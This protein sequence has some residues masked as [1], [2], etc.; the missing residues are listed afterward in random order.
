M[1]FAAEFINTLQV[2]L[3]PAL[4]HVPLQPAK[5]EFPEAF[6]VKVTVDPPE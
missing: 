4:A 3:V 1:A 2:G 5:I 6:A